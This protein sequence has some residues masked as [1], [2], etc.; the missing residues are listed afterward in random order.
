MLRRTLPYR[1]PE[2]LV[3]QLLGKGK[4]AGDAMAA[5]RQRS[6]RSRLAASSHRLVHVAN[7]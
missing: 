6:T 1:I 2:A 4:F 3:G 7:I 5:L